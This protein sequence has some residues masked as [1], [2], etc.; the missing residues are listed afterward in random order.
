MDSVFKKKCGMNDSNLNSEEG[1]QSAQD[2]LRFV[3]D[4]PQKLH[5]EVA[6]SHIP[7]RN[8]MSWKVE[9]IV[10]FDKIVG[11]PLEVFAGNRMIARGEVVRINDG[12]GIRVTE[13]THPDDQRK[14]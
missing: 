6:R 7:L 5:A 8:V 12:F 1:K 10:E 2:R 9:S 13:I 14:N 4:M 11:E 3:A